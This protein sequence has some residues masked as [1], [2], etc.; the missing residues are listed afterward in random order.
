MRKPVWLKVKAPCGDGFGHV[1]AI[2]NDTK[3]STVCQEARC[4]NM[5]ECWAS[6]TAT[7]MLMGEVCTRACRFCNVKTGAP[8]PLDPGE[9]ER[10]ALAVRALN[11]KYLVLT[12]VDRDDLPDGGASHF[13]NAIS[14]IRLESPSTRIEVLIPDFNGSK[15]SLDLLAKARPDVIG[16]NLETVASLQS[17]IRDRRASYDQSLSLLGYVKSEHKTPTKSSLMLGM[18]ETKPEILQCLTDLRSVGV[19]LL[20][21]GQ[22]LQ[23]SQFHLKVER[24]YTP[25]EFDWLRDQALTMGFRFVAA[26][27]L[28]RSSYRA[29]ES[30]SVLHPSRD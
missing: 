11:L 6:G 4:P 10:L 27:P 8:D 7:V 1:K 20:T 15:P 14:A 28:V 3:L 9:P 2:L 19:D 16:H 21:M 29:F 13:A 18:G 17:R 12:S 5:G 26:G 25:E 30:T 23:P 22:Y 24:F